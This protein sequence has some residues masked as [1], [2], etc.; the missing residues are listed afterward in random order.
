LSEGLEKYCITLSGK[1]D[2]MPRPDF[3]L[4]LPTQIIFGRNSAGH[5]I[6]NIAAIGERVLLVHGANAKRAAWLIT[7]LQAEGLVIDTVACPREPDVALIEQCVARGRAH[8][9][10]AVIGLGGGAV[11]DTAKALAGL[12]PATGSV[13]DYL[14]VVGEGKRLDAHPLAWAALPTT[15]GTGAEVTR[16]AVIDVPAAKRKVSLRDNRLLPTLAIIDSALT[17]QTPREVTLAS[18]LDAITQVIEPWISGQ[19]NRFTDALCRDA[20]ATGLNALQALMAVPEAEMQRQTSA[21]D[22]MAWVSL[23]GGLALANA[24]LGAVHGLAGPL[25]GVISAPHGAIAGRLLP[26]VLSANQQACRGEAKQRIDEVQDW[27]AQSFNISAVQAFAHLAT[28][29]QQQG[30]PGLGAMGL[31]KAD[32]PRV[33]QAALSS[34]SMQ[35]NP[36]VL[37]EA[38][39][40]DVLTNAD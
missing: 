5:H 23:C 30:L 21:R 28:W 12:I 20:I 8:A 19:A 10:D 38:T 24:K 2:F 25:G 18:G 11:I 31:C 39:L 13:L 29:S 35:G 37:S 7:A 34:S 27:I 22:E 32:R 17:D 16:N 36:V 6:A 3:S 1:G 9:C 40:I 33:A 15:A 4:H 26:Y 14:E